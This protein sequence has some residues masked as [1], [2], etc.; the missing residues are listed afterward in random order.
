[1][2]LFQSGGPPDREAMTKLRTE[3]SDKTMA[4]LTAEQKDQLTKMQG[5][6][7]DI[8]PSQLRGMGAGRGRNRDGGGNGGGGNGGGG[9]DG[10]G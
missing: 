5:K 2:D 1:M 3:Q 8:D 9:K 10:S 4:V 7:L 6:T